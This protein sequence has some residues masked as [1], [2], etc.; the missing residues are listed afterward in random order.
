[1]KIH[2]IE[3]YIQ[4]LFIAEYPDKLLL[5]DG[6][7]KADIQTIEN[8]IQKNLNKPL[9]ELK[10]IVVTHMH[11]DHAGAASI[12][13]KKYGIPLAAH[14]EI[15]EWYAG[16]GGFLQNRADT[17]MAHIVAHKKKKPY[18]RLKYKRFVKPDYFLK[19]AEKLPFFPD[20]QVFHTPGHTDHDISLFHSETKTLYAAD[21][22]LQIKEKCRLPFPTVF[23]HRLKKSILKVADLNPKKILLAHGDSCKELLNPIDYEKLAEQTEI[24]HRGIFK[25]L[26]PFVKLGKK[27]K[28]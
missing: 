5:L 13:R 17:F 14:P 18:R 8:F 22:F 24:K 15:D 28:S 19:N 12:L 2:K 11:P 23:P 20:W 16:F 4:N 7:S 3:G 26:L 10:L 25:L 21:L 9:S 6:G 1:V 27:A